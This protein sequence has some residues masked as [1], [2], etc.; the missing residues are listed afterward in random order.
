MCLLCHVTQIVATRGQTVPAAEEMADAAP[1]PPPSSSSPPPSSPLPSSPPPS[2]SSSSAASPSKGWK[3]F[4]QSIGRPVFCSEQLVAEQCLPF[5]RS[6]AI[7]FHFVTGVA[8]PSLDD[9]YDNYAEAC[10]WLR[11]V[12]VDTIDQL[13]RQFAS[14]SY[15]PS[16]LI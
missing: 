11:Y 7:M 14:W 6:S 4:H 2:S 5:L 13:V 1:P 9:V 16:N 15:S 12:G 10:V 3:E 8:F